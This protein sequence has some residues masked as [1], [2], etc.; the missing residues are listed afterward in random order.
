MSKLAQKWFKDNGIKVLDW[1]AQSPDLNPIEHLWSILK[2]HLAAYPT[3]PPSIEELWKRVEAEWEKIPKEECLK[4]INSM[5]RRV[6]A[7]LK[8]KGGYTKY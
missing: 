6:A 2:F 3:P 8:V 4:L 1:P 7:V 5:P